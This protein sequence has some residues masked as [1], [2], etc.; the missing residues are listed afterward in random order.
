VQFQGHFDQS[1][2]F[3]VSTTCCA[4]QYFVLEVRQSYLPILG[5]AAR[6]CPE[7]IEIM[8][9]S[10]S[11]SKALGTRHITQISK[12]EGCGPSPG[13]RNLSEEPS[14][15]SREAESEGYKLN[16]AFVIACSC[17]SDG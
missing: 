2:G 6:N 15:C 14:V 16:I 12:V 8:E 11:R 13:A 4:V 3:L 9:R 1:P 7:I 10:I 5:M 17:I